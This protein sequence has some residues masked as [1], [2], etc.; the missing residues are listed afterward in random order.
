[1]F[2]YSSSYRASFVIK[3]LLN[4]HVILRG[5]RSGHNLRA[6]NMADAFTLYNFMVMFLVFNA[7]EL[8]MRN[9]EVQVK[10]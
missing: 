10:S 2:E 4:F 3:S 9:L 5:H 7:C 6:K 8:T 1:M